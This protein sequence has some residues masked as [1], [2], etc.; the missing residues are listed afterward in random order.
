[1]FGGLI[2]PSEGCGLKTP[3]LTLEYYP[4]IIGIFKEYLFFRADAVAQ[5][6]NSY[7]CRN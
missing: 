6:G 7:S 3:D 2:K 5:F 4:K 1:L